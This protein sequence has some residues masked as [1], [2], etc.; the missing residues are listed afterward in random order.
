MNQLEKRVQRLLQQV[1]RVREVSVSQFAGTHVF[2]VVL[3]LRSHPLE[4][5]VRWSGEGWPEDLRRQLSTESD[6]T[7]PGEV[8]LAKRFSPGAE[9][10][11]RTLQV[12][13]ADESGEAH[14][15]LDGLVVESARPTST[16]QRPVRIGDEFEWSNSSLDIAEAL[17]T[18]DAGVQITIED[19]ARL[20]SWSTAQVASVL[21]RFEDRGWIQNAGAQRGRGA[22][23]ILADKAGMRNDWVSAV[24][25]RPRE[26]MF[27][28]TSAKDLPGYLR[29]ELAPRLDTLGDWAASGWVAADFLA[30]Y[31]SVVPS[32]QIYLPRESFVRDLIG[33]LGVT[34]VESGGAIEFWPASRATLDLATRGTGELPVV[35]ADRVY[36]DLTSLG[37]R[38]DDAASHLREELSTDVP[39]PAQAGRGDPD[40]ESL[41]KWQSASLRRHGER[42]NSLSPDER[43]TRYQRG[44]WSV[45]YILSGPTSKLT[46]VELH[47]ALLR[48]KGHETGWPVW[49]ITDIPDSNP[50]II[51]GV[52]E[53]WLMGGRS[54]DS[55]FWR[56]SKDGAFFL[57]RTFDEDGPESELR[58]GSTLSLTLPVWRVGECVR[59]AGRMAAEFGAEAIDMLVSWEGL[60]D[61]E[62]S[63]WPTRGR[64][65]GPGRV[66]RQNTLET[67]VRV[68]PEDAI[69][70]A[71]GAVRELVEPLYELFDFF[72]PPQAM[73]AEELEK[74]AERVG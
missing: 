34:P 52:I 54:S 25:T 51:D 23:R 27:A 50:E 28:H 4:L 65:M 21:K 67:S 71:P 6:F 32:L 2:A 45:S 47:D 26:R 40:L 74:L 3:R 13:W 44:Y 18:F 17:L 55:D 15:H 66:A 24:S 73:Y 72:V 10:V 39:P 63:S 11:L 46:N 60:A 35:T 22:R 53:C 5:R 1:T 20:T 69:D 12:N 43:P 64:W 68:R 33:E 38:G 37:G 30:P 56:A 70:G 36:A 49:M 58:P 14:I 31:S 61:R 16:D 8:F 41:H 59:H 29:E 42:M 48:N 9:E 19:T 7:P 57:L 62:L